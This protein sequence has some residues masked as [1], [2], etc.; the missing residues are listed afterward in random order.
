MTN[1]NEPGASTTSSTGHQLSAGTYLDTHFAAVRTEYEAAARFAG[2]QPGWS[3]LDAGAGGG[4]FLPILSEIVGAQGAIEAVDIDP[5]NIQMIQAR[6]QSGM[7]GCPVNAHVSPITALPYADNQFDAIWCANVFQYLSAE[8]VT[9]AVGEF[10]R[11][12]RPGGLVVVKDADL[13]AHLIGS[14]PTLF[15]HAI[16]QASAHPDMG[17]H[18]R[19]LL[20]IP[21]VPHV[22]R[23]AGIA[24]IGYKTFVSEWHQ[25]PHATDRPYLE[26][27]MALWGAISKYLQLP[28]HEV[29]FWQRFTDPSAQDYFLNSPDFYYR[30]GF[31]VVIGKVSGTDA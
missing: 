10:R 29:S 30:E 21:Q 26:T 16:E 2:F 17:A 7:F 31:V 8:E 28:G 27:I 12:V 1:T 22:Y 4:S 9:H 18:F 23:A 19:N 11:V 6:V 13:S 15:W 25:P 24:V 3:I 14:V 5:Q 20:R